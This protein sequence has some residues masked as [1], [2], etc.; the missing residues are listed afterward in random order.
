MKNVLLLLAVVALTLVSC[1]KERTDLVSNE[2]MGVQSLN[3]FE[4]LVK[5]G[6]YPINKLSEK[7][8]QSFKENLVFTPKN[9]VAGGYIGD[10]EKELSETEFSLFM[11]WIMGENAIAVEPPVEVS[12]IESRR[13]CPDPFEIPRYVRNY[14]NIGTSPSY[15]SGCTFARERFCAVCLGQL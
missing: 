13:G 6:V 12:D 5:I 3:D 4:H 10:V 2:I 8:I 11:E 7:A 15:F 9:K 1:S 14:R